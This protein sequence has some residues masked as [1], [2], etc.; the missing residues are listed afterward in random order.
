MKQYIFYGAYILSGAAVLASLIAFLCRLRKGQ[1][2]SPDVP[3]Y[4]LIAYFTLCVI[5]LMF[6]AAYIDI[7]L[8]VIIEISLA[9]AA[10][11]AMRY[12]TK[13]K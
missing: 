5:G 12:I 4:A 8:L 3:L 6:D 13:R 10:I 9:A 2:I 11:F 1:R 7:Q